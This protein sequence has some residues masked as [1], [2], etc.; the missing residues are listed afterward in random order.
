MRYAYNKENKTF[1]SEKE[2][3]RCVSIG[4]A[5]HVLTLSP[6][7]RGIGALVCWKW[8][9][10][11]LGV[12][13]ALFS[14][15]VHCSQFAVRIE[16]SVPNIHNHHYRLN[17][18]KKSSSFITDIGCVWR[19]NPEEKSY[20]RW[21]GD[22]FSVKLLHESGNLTPVIKEF[23]SAF[24]H[25]VVTMRAKAFSE[26]T[27]PGVF[28]WGDFG[29]NTDQ[30]YSIGA[31][32]RYKNEFKIYGRFRQNNLLFGKRYGLHGCR[33]KVIYGL[34]GE[35]LFSSRLSKD[36]MSGK[37]WLFGGYT[38]PYST[39]LT[40]SCR[41][42]VRRVSVVG[43]AYDVLRRGV[44]PRAVGFNVTTSIPNTSIKIDAGLEV[45]VYQRPDASTSLA[46]LGVV[47]SHKWKLDAFS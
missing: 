17:L 16:R 47:Y 31:G 39:K 8:T 26:V 24:G 30:T 29:F 37:F 12:L 46:Y 22:Y 40:G 14:G 10:I 33:N 18:I 21:R 34:R 38:L 3:S 36:E 13:V 25:E 5:L 27:S 32:A 42:D 44:L 11:S 43:L 19:L 6:F 45:A 23:R 41:F 9:L 7:L 2:A 1:N 28:V 15:Q 35:S 20:I 4:L